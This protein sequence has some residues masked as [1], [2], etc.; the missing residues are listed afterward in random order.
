[1]RLAEISECGNGFYSELAV[2]SETRRGW[3][4]VSDLLAGTEKDTRYLSVSL[5]LY[6]DP[7]HDPEDVGVSD[8]ENALQELNKD[9]SRKIPVYR[10]GENCR[11]GQLFYNPEKIVC[12]GLNYAE[13]ATEFNESAPEEPAI[14][15]KSPSA[16]NYSGGAIRIPR[17]SNR[18]D[19]EGELVV[20]IGSTCRNV[21]EDDALKYVA[22]Y[23]CGNDVSA[24]DW[25]KGKPSGQWFL[26]KSFDTFAPVGPYFVTA[27]EVGDPNN[28]KIETR[29]NGKTVQSANTSQTICNVQYLVAYISQVMTLTTGDLIFTGTPSGVGDARKPPV[30][31]KSGDV[32]EVEIE[33]LGVLSN[34]V[35]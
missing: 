9:E 31:L 27:D 11:Y 32:V 1:M 25:Q 15:C 33:K 26:G 24:R 6:R 13:H 4:L 22:G 16:L 23:C 30:Y 35:D 3:I 21:S 17:V 19:Y 20:V 34:S 29:L 5:M 12:A 18:V 8:I 10:I 2:W 7:P 14:F 28:L